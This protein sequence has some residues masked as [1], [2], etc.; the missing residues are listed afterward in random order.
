MRVVFIP[1]H[2]AIVRSHLRY[3]IGGLHT[4]YGRQDRLEEK[5]QNTATKPFQDYKAINNNLYN[6][7]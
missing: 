1:V 3:C 5:T 7:H 4:C 2:K 6:M